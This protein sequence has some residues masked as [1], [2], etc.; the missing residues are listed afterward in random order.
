METIEIRGKQVKVSKEVSEYI[1]D[2]ELDI[3]MLKDIS[4]IYE[5]RAGDFADEAKKNISRME[6]LFQD[7]SN[8]TLLSK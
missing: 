7:L 1:K 8:T 2:L 5:S 3:K 6:A 4:K